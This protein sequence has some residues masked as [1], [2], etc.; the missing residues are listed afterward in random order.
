MESRYGLYWRFMCTIGVGLCLNFMRVDEKN[1]FKLFCFVKREVV[2]SC[3]VTI[4]SQHTKDTGS[5]LSVSQGVGCGLHDCHLIQFLFRV[6]FL[7]AACEL[8]FTLGQFC[9]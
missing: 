4:A 1:F 6:F 9:G 3:K 7:V 5:H 8:E 2:Q